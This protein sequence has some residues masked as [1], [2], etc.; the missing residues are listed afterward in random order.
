MK[1]LRNSI[2]A[3]L[4]I[5]FAVSCTDEVENRPVVA[6]GEAPVL[7]ATEEGNIYVLS[8][9][10]MDVLAERFVWSAANLGNGIIPTYDVEITTENDTDFATP[11]V[12]GTTNGTLQFAASHSVLNTALLRLNITPFQSA[13][14]NVR[15]KAH[16]GDVV[17]YSNVVEMIITPYTTETPKLWINGLF[18][19]GSGYGT[20]FSTAP[21]LM[22]TAYGNPNFEGYLYIASNITDAANGFKFSN[23]ANTNG[24]NYGMGASAGKLLPT[25]GNITADAGYY[26]VKANTDLLTYSL[27]QTSWGIVGNSTPGGWD[28]STPMTYDPAT[29][30]WT[31]VA[32]MTVQTAPDNGWKFRANNAWDINLG[33]T[34]TN[35]TDGT[36]IYGGSNIGITTAGTYKITLDLSNPRA[37]TYTIERQ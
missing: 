21:Q 16:V 36:L 3:V 26:L 24:V 15:I 12:I 23:Q 19:A 20:D 18:Q 13:N 28:N 34:V 4:A 33:D 22:S 27:T 29:K 5:F 7:T 2:I 25:G 10:T 35:Q 32:A 14:F 11:S 30:K 37:Y 1:T 8:P 9:E 17:A 31:V 6:A